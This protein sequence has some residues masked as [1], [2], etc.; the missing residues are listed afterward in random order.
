MIMV[1]FYTYIVN[2]IFA[3]G[4]GFSKPQTRHVLT[5]IHGII[6][7]DGKKTVS[8]IRR[9][10]HETRDLSSMTR[11]LN[12]SPWCPN[13]ANRRRIQFM[14]EKIKKARAKQGDTRPITFLIMDDTQSKKDS[15]THGMEGLDYH[16]SHSDG[17]S[18]WS[19]CV[20][21]AH[22]V[23]EGYSFALDYRS[24]FRDSYCSENGLAFKSKNDLAIE[25]INGYESPSDEQV[26]VLVDSWYT[27]KKL[28]DACST[29]GYHLIGGLRTNRKIYP[30][31]I[32]IKLSQFISDYIQADDLRPV[33]VGHHRYKIYSYEGNLSD[34]ENATI[35][36]SWED[37]YD[38]KTKPFCLLCTD[39]SLDLVTILRYYEVRW[40]IETGY[41]YFKDL[42]GFDH[43]QLLS[44]KG[45]ERFWC[46]QFL[47]YNFLESQRKEWK[48]EGIVTI[49]DTVR[50]IRKDHLSQLIVYSYEQGLTQKPLVEVLK[51]LKLSA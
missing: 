23:S 29:N 41:R 38:S 19:H 14:M 42:L 36:V 32:G 49:G 48:E 45:I 43:Y 13:R 3:L 50:R 17:K 4:L 9:F 26:Y 25:L 20:V 28:I 33:T 7:A 10:T 15:H 46:L 30:A 44:Y 37:K 16:F 47:T 27:S 18:V 11:F 22:V 12:E 39:S 8:N 6:L 34:T 5:F 1:T 35:L 51:C 24:Y 31:G 40:H 21:T 2:F